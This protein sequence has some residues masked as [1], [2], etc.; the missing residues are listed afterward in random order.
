MTQERIVPYAWLGFVVFGAVMLSAIIARSPNTHGHLWREVPPDYVRTPVD[1]IEKADL[2]AIVAQL[3]PFV[4][5]APAGGQLVSV[6]APSTAS[7]VGREEGKANGEPVRAAAPAAAGAEGVQ[8]ITFVIPHGSF[9]PSRLDVKAGVPVEFTVTNLH[10]AMCAIT[11]PDLGV[12]ENLTPG[13][14]K[15]LRFTPSEPGQYRGVCPYSLW[16]NTEEHAHGTLF[17]NVQ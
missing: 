11:L 15:V 3:P 4:P 16:G 7:A 12:A 6:V 13:Q 10:G 9:S 1:A 5:P 14:Q 2:A 8:Q 17:V